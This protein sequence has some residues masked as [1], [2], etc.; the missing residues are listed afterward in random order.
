MF[1]ESLFTP[2]QVTWQ[3][4]QP[5]FSGNQLDDDH[6]WEETGGK[7]M[8]PKWL[9]LPCECNRGATDFDLVLIWLCI[10]GNRKCDW[11][12][13]GM[14]LQYF[15]I[16][17]YTVRIK[18]FFFSFWRNQCALLFSVGSRQQSQTVWHLLWG[19]QLFY[20]ARWAKVKVAQLRLFL[21]HLFVAIKLFAFFFFFF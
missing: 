17:F 4:F 3:Q 2:S 10:V 12:V 8:E 18:L 7:P 15:C 20:V 16:W 1:S 21:R 9:K 5:Q 11:L 19:R 13:Q 6:R 14:M